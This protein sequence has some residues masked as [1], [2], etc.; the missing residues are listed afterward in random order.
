VTFIQRF[1]SALNL[2]P[3]FHSLVLDGVYPGPA[4]APGPFLAL[5]PPENE[6]VARVMAGVPWVSR[7]RITGLRCRS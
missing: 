3:H 1:G 5:P 2:A 4:Y 7:S 6:D